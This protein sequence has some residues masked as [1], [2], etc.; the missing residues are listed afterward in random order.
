[1]ESSLQ[2]SPAA[3]L[4]F[5][6]SLII[7]TSPE[8][9]AWERLLSER[10][11]TRGSICSFLFLQFS[12]SAVLTGGQTSQGTFSGKVTAGHTPWLSLPNTTG[13]A[14][15]PSG[16]CLVNAGV[17]I[18]NQQSSWEWGSKSEFLLSFAGG[19][20][21]PILKFVCPYK[22]SVL[23]HVFRHTEIDHKI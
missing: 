18:W 14:V 16:E 5:K 3:E 22:P 23:L 7:N 9:K 21:W 10:G 12:P 4:N 17:E 19:F 13:S 6:F 20:Q 8:L 15:P 2:A 11:F 1:M